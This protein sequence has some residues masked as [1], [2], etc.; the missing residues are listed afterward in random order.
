MDRAAE[1][2]LEK[3]VAQRA[4]TVLQ[5]GLPARPDAVDLRA[6]SRRLGELGATPVTMAERLHEVFE[7]SARV[8][9]PSS[10][11]ACKKGCS[12]C[13]HLKVAVTEIEAFAI[14]ARLR[15]AGP[16]SV[17]AFRERAPTTAGRTAADR[18][19]AKQPCP[20][21]AEG[22]CSVYRDRPLSCRVVVSFDVTPC[23]EEFEGQSGDIEIPGHYTGHARNV[24]AALELAMAEAKRPLRYFEL[25]AAVLCVLDTPSAEARWRRGNDIFAGLPVEADRSS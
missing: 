3:A 5:T 19:G 21:L 25:G 10:R 12:Y 17:A 1:R 24:V 14:A 16:R 6:L 13:C 20:L 7:V 18:L 23:E 2:Q 8:G 15:K 9:A 22:A 4:R 11:L